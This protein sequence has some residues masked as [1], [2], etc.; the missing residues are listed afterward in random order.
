MTLR[1]GFMG[2]GWISS[3]V[4]TDFRHEGLQIRAVGS[5]TLVKAQ[6]FAAEFGISTAHGT[7]DA[8]AADPDV[9]IVY[10]TLLNQAHFDGAMLAIE[11]GKH[12]LVEKPFMMTSAQAASVAAMANKRGVFAMEA[13]WSRFTPSQRAL[14]QALLDGIIGTPHTITAHYGEDLVDKPRVWAP[15]QG[16]GALMDLGVY[17]LAFILNIFGPAESVQARAVLTEQ[18]V[19]RSIAV[20]T[21]HADGRLG[22]FVS[23]ISASSRPC[24]TVLGT[25]GRIEVWDKLWGQAPWQVFSN[26]GEL[27]R[28]YSDTVPGSGR[29][30]QALEVE[31]CIT[32]GL[33]ESPLMPLDESVRIMAYIE[34]IRSQTGIQIERSPVF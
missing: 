7:Y 33:L 27:L 2:T 11:H 6:S 5:S 1:W 9:D 20:N 18:H 15:E 24:A 22:S 19:D 21:T 3:T 25:N 14:K 10:V 13:M 17:P 4:A 16:G 26:A 31:R 23:T 32:A 28:D 30:Y 34:D 29:Q 8:L 12:V